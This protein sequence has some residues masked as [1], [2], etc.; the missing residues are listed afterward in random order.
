M[1]GRVS[2]RCHRCRRCDHGLSMLELIV[3]L[4]IVAVLTAYA[5]PSLV[6]QVA[7]GHR[8]D[9]VIAL[10]RAARFIEAYGGNERGIAA[11]PSG[12]DQA[13]ADGAAV[14]LLRVLP[15]DR[16]NGG[17]AIEAVPV[18]S[19]PMRDDRCGIYALDASGKRTNRMGQGVA[20][21]GDC[22]LA[23]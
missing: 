1:S 8:A 11:L 17:Y 12:L 18:E 21:A 23:R 10:H 7:R 15:A 19:G 5:I 6:G 20:R 4:A 9:A 13:P 22:W 16:N 14:Y 3:A 2:C